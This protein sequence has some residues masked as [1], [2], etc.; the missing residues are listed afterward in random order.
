MGSGCE[1]VFTISKD[2]LFLL[3]FFI[4][5]FGSEGY[6]RKKLGLPNKKEKRVHPLQKWLDF[7][8]DTQCYNLNVFIRWSNSKYVYIDLS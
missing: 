8:D 7:T 5:L 6:L 3:S 2:F 1:M 4:L